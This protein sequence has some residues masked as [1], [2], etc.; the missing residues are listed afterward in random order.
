MKPKKKFKETIVGKGLVAITSIVNPTLGN[1]VAGAINITEAVEHVIKDNALS[2]E[3]KE[4][5][6][7]HL[8]DLEMEQFKAEIADRQS[9]RQREMQAIKS[10]TSDS[11]FKVVGW[12]ITLA[13]LGVVFA[14][15]FI[16][17]PQENQRAFDMAFGSV[18]SAFVSVY[19]Y[20]FGS[21]KSSRDKTAMLN[22]K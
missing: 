5:I 1:L 16:D 15:I 2:P 20:Y 18:V 3:Q 8:Q 12:G 4:N 9:A 21:S 17:I 10:N 13:F 14:A 19:G 6:K 22:E 11:L 7:M